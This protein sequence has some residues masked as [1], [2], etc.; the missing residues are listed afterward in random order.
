GGPWHS[1]KVSDSPLPQ[2][3]RAL[4]LIRD[5]LAGDAY[6]VETIFNPYKVA[7]NLSKPEE[8]ARLR[9]EKPQVLLDA[10]EIIGRSEA[11]HAKRAIA[12]GAS[13]IFL[14]IANAQPEFM[15]PS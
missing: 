8:V 5:G 4:E 10:L 2:Q 9:Q 11:N 7:E 12:A 6:F 3:V 13:G 14:A 15:S 1:L